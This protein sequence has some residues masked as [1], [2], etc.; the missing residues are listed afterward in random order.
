MHHR[1]AVLLIHRARMG[2]YLEWSF[3]KEESRRKFLRSALVFQ[4]LGGSSSVFI[5]TT[6]ASRRAPTQIRTA[7]KRR[8]GFD[9]GP[10]GA[11]SIDERP[12][13]ANSRAMNCPMF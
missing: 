6:R 3:R 7:I 13:S 11:N 4:A 2:W 9:A 10:K 8:K 5:V 1:R 12:S